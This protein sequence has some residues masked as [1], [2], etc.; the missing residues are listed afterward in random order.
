MA[1]ALFSLLLVVGLGFTGAATYK[2]YTGNCPLGLLCHGDS[3]SASVN[4]K[5][6]CCGGGSCCSES[7]SAE[8]CTGECPATK[9]AKGEGACCTEGKC[10]EGKAKKDGECC[11]NGKCCPDGACCGDKTK[12]EKKENKEETPK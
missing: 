12:T 4:V 3:D 9:E 1:K 11:P 8:A 6:N 10:C 7:G 5:K 2:W